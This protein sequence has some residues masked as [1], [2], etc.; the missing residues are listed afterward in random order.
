[1][2]QQKVTVEGETPQQHPR[3]DQ[4]VAWAKVEG[5][6][7]NPQEQDWWEDWFHCFVNGIRIGVETSVNQPKGNRH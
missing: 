6:E 4:F 3:W 5:L 1:M 7:L 2:A